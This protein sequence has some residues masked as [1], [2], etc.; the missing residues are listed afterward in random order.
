MRTIYDQLLDARLNELQDHVENAARLCDN[1]LG[2]HDL[3]DI[4]QALNKAL[5]VIARGSI[6]EELEALQDRENERQL[7]N[8]RGK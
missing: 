4:E 5:E 1:A 6:D 2:E 8:K 3:K 7:N